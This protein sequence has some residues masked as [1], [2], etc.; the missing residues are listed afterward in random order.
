MRYLDLLQKTPS[1]MKLDAEVLLSFAAKMDRANLLC[2]LRKTVSQ[3][4]FCIFDELFQKRCQGW[5]VAYLLGQKEFMGLDF[6]VDPHVLI[7]RPETETL[8]E[9]IQDIF[10]AQAE[11]CS[12]L[13]IGTGSGCIAISLKKS[14]PEMRV[15]ATDSEFGA[16][17]IAKK[18][19]EKHKTLVQFLC[20][21]IMNGLNFQF[22]AIA[23]NPPYIPQ[24]DVP[25]LPIEVRCEPQQALDGGESGTTIIK[26]IIQQAPQLLKPRGWLFLEIALGQASIVEGLFLEK[27]KRVYKKNDLSGIE[28]V[29]YGQI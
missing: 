21:D 8:V 10:Q 3:E 1:D 7:P 2:D 14:L 15:Y 11:H 27:F 29:I 5:P 6:E 20:M 12:L 23:S 18:N 22:N 26:R 25:N 9:T 16:L 4:T 17:K 24:E 28:R 19:S 13:D